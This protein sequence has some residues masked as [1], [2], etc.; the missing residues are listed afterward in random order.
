[1]P[2]LFE[3]C[4]DGVSSAKPKIRKAEGKMQTCLRFC[5]DQA[6]VSV[7]Q[8]RAGRS[9]PAR[10]PAV[11]CRTSVHS[12]GCS[13]NW[14]VYLIAP[15]RICARRAQRAAASP[16]EGPLFASR[17]SAPACPSQAADRLVILNLR[18]Q[19]NRSSP[20][21]PPG[22][23]L[24]LRVPQVRSC[25]PIRSAAGLTRVQIGL[26]KAERAAACAGRRPAVRCRTCAHSAGCDP[27][28]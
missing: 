15:F 14:K 23:G 24:H 26:A 5:R 25:R 10:R 28:L 2:N 3:H 20:Q 21:P 11:R 17:R 27:I 6:G 16:R 12:A 9:L 22:G 13:P 18:F 1:M 7:R 8:D 4:R 19:R